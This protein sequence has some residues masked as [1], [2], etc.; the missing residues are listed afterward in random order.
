MARFQLYIRYTVVLPAGE[1][2]PEG[3]EAVNHFIVSQDVQKVEWRSINPTWARPF[4]P[5][6]PDDWQ[7]AWVVQRGEYAGTLPK[8]IRSYYYKAHGIKC[9][10]SFIEQ[11]GNI[12]RQH[13]A[14]EAR[15]LFEI[16][17]EFNWEAGDFGDYGSCYWGGN[18]GAREMLVENGGLAI[19]FFTDSGAGYA[20]A[21]LVEVDDDLFI[22]F[23]GYGFGRGV[24]ATLTI[25][26]VFST[27]TTLSYKKISLDNRTGSTLY[28]NGDIGYIIG[29]PENIAQIDSW[30]FEWHDIYVDTCAACGTVVAED[31]TYF[32]TDDM[33]Y[34]YDCYV[35]LFDRCESC[36]EL[37]RSEDLYYVEA[38]DTYVCRVCRARE[39][40]RCHSCNEWFEK[41]TLHIHQMYAYCWQCLNEETTPPDWAE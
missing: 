22:I 25:A 10:D 21:W 37:H 24:N 1:L 12:A 5:P 31:D 38:G 34:C 35:E 28:I 2:S 40:D 32:G 27:F 26:R 36:E 3:T 15:Y 33:P 9:P 41:G 19:C 6:L 7:W 29:T 4:L 20:R 13:T 14:A 18:A 39:Y 8:R 30:D 23:N 11:I 17:N 16:V